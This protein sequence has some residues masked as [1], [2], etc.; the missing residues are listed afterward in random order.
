MTHPTKI[1]CVGAGSYSFGLSAVVA[2]LRSPALKGSELVLVD[3][4]EG[5]LEIMHQ[6]MSWLNDAWYSQMTITAT[7][8]HRDALKG[9]QFVINAI[10][11][12]PREAL[13]ESDYLIP[14]K[15]GV[16][17]PYAENSGPGA[18]PTQSAISP[19]S[20]RSR[21]IWKPSARM[22]GSSISPT[23]CSAFVRRFT[24]TQRLK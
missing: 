18:S 14:L 24:V 16:R 6:L 1:V 2:L 20:S 22:H 15:Y 5:H 21:V 17:Q 4:N 10:E 23:P 8:D 12:G 11:V 3:L 13:W 9:A 7:T 19:P